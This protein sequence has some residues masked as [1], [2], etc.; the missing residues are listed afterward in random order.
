MKHYTLTEIK[1]LR[2][3]SIGGNIYENTCCLSLYNEDED[4]NE[5]DTVS[6]ELTQRDIRSMISSLALYLKSEVE[7]GE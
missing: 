2:N 6:I 5:S 3:Y 7:E 4:G 1:Q